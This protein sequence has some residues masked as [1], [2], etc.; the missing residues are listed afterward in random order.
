[1]NLAAKLA[2]TSDEVTRV[3]RASEAQKRKTALEDK[4]QNF[5]AMTPKIL[6]DG[7]AAARRE[8]K[9]GGRLVTVYRVGYSHPDNASLKDSSDSKEAFANASA[10]MKSLVHEFEKAGF[11]VL[12]CSVSSCPDDPGMGGH[13][14]YAI[15]IGW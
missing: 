11:Q 4:V 7:L 3:R 12:C 9:K 2:K 14:H 8:A 13:D 10:P 1:M 5:A 6:R 15:Q